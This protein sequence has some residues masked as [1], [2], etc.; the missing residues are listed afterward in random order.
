MGACWICGNPATTAEH[1]IK[2]SDLVRVHGRGDS[3]TSASLN[4]LRSDDT[5]VILQ[6]PDSKL[7]KWPNNLCAPCNNHKTQPID[8]AYEKFIQYVDAHQADL[9][10]RR[11]IDF[12]SVYGD[13]WR[14]EQVNLFK[15][16]AKTLGC[17]ISGVGRQVPPDIIAVMNTEIFETALNVC[18]AVN[19]DEIL[20]PAAE[21]AKLQTG[22]LI[23][24]NVRHSCYASA[25]FYR[26]L[27]FTF[28]YG[29]GPFGPVGSRWCADLQFVSIGSYSAAESTPNIGSTS[30][31]ISWP[32]F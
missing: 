5:V 7:V 1:K 32:G 3:F 31:P 27:I 17:K 20:K 12:E 13:N 2:K 25:Y 10:I 15:Y 4:Y 9:L 22:N 29:W 24:S 30:A 19:E 23:V 26:W 6:G 11:Q 28:W 8:R 16:F 21:Q 14:I 18:I